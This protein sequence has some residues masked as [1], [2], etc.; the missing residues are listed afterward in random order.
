MAMAQDQA[1][2]RTRARGT[3]TTL[4]SE[5]ADTVEPGV[6]HIE[7]EPGAPTETAG[8]GALQIDDAAGQ[9][10]HG[11]VTNRPATGW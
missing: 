7:I 2:D 5:P 4:T 9:R 1:R 3:M 10:I 6:A 8:S 11:A